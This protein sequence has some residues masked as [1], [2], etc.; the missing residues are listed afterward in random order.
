M[1]AKLRYLYIGSLKNSGMPSIKIITVDFYELVLPLSTSP[2]EQIIKSWFESTT[3]E[4]RTK[5]IN[6]KHIRLAEAYFGPQ[7]PVEIHFLRDSP[8][9]M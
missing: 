1:L 3:L 4:T 9:T 5:E 8:L 7:Q 2:F 6:G